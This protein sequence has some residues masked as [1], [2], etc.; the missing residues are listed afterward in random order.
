MTKPT[1]IL[2][3]GSN[4]TKHTLHQ[5][6]HQLLGDYLYI[7]S[8]A[9]DDGLPE[10][11]EGDIVLYSSLTIKEEV[12]H[13]I[14][15]SDANSVIGNR[16]VHH[17]HIDQLLRIPSGTKVLVVN[18]D[19]T[20]TTE[21]IQSLYQLGIN[22]IR[23]VAFKQDDDYIDGVTYAIT[24]GEEGLCPPYVDTVVNIG[25]RLFDMATILKVVEW[26]SLDDV[27]AMRISERYIRNIIE[28]QRKL[29]HAQQETSKVYKHIQSVVDSVDDG[30]I[31]VNERQEITV[32]NHRVK[33]LFH[34]PANGVINQRITDVLEQKEITN[35]I[36]HGEEES[37]FFTIHGVEVVIFRYPMKQENTIVATFKSVNQAFEIERKAKH[38]L[39]DKGFYSKYDFSDIVGNHPSILEAKQIAKKLALSEYPILIQGETGT[40]K[41]LFAHSIHQHSMRKNGP[42]LAINC[43]AMTESLLESEL[44]GYEEGTFTGGQRGGKKGLFE[45]AENGTIFLDE[46]GDISMTLQS[47][48]LRVLQ[49]KEVRRIGGRKIIPINVR[50]ISATNKNIEDKIEER[51]FRSDLFYR[52]NVLGLSVPEL[53][54]RKTDIPLL[55][56]HFVTKN[57]N[58]MKFDD[59]VMDH[60]LSYHWP[61]NVRELKN[62]IDYSLT[63]S[64]TNHI[65]LRDLPMNRF[66]IS[67]DVNLASHALPKSTLSQQEH[68]II[69]DI[70]K[71]CNAQGKPASR[72]HISEKSEKTPIPLSQQQIRRRL[73]DLEAQGY[74]IKGK[75][76]AG[77]KITTE[78]V[79]YLSRL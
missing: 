69:L 28:L 75:G 4:R 57:G 64:D 10:H 22:H 41:E 76:R 71:Q 20:A 48:L 74:V 2:L 9:A 42:F 60:L 72:M 62:I 19:Y 18:D 14:S 34:T 25:V 1:L 79:R 13:L 7:K 67:N 30:I 63:V 65:R 43:S 39:R 23:P 78:G 53:N 24:P 27:V 70:I 12:E 59:K 50:I 51:W 3:A 66:K 54:R 61:G 16:T 29:L 17:E 36:L 37:K 47:H 5:Q 21:L 6:L 44:F 77:T 8:Y 32:F 38:N 58:W 73:D 11:I 56:D 68:A 45:L 31:A 35:F 40:G 26:C 33:G 46:I 49:E 52:L 15:F 55:V